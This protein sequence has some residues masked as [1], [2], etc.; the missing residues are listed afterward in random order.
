MGMQIEKCV[1]IINKRPLKRG[2][3]Q[4]VSLA[5]LAEYGQQNVVFAERL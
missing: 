2:I 5:F 1:L 3:L 4:T